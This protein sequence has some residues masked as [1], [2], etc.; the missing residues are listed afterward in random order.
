MTHPDSA[1]S[2]TEVKLAWSYALLAK[3]FTEM[4]TAFACIN[5][6]A[7]WTVLAA[8]N[9][10]MTRSLRAEEAKFAAKGFS[11]GELKDIAER[12]QTTLATAGRAVN[13]QRDTTNAALPAPRER[14]A[15]KRVARQ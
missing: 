11:R 5:S 15:Q 7:A 14:G 2:V 12:L 3:A 9:A 10:E 4:A 1:P 13:K 6:E 8:T